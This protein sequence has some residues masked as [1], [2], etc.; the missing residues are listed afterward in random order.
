M[1]N[2]DFIKEC[3]NEHKNA[4]EN[5]YFG[6]VVKIW[7]ENGI[8]CIK[9]SNGTWFHYRKNNKNNNCIEWW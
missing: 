2:D 3:V 7:E 5:W 9:Y 6:E 4:V 1:I 8:L